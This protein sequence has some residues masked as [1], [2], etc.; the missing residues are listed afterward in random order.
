VVIDKREKDIEP[1]GEGGEVP[2]RLPNAQAMEERVEYGPAD[3]A[4]DEAR[5][6][7]AE[8]DVEE[9]AHGRGHIGGDRK[10]ALDHWRIDAQAPQGDKA[11]KEIRDEGAEVVCRDRFHRGSVKDG[12]SRLTGVPVA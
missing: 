4:H 1:L 8:R 3:G 12:M 6:H 2:A 11:G 5:G 9:T 10:P 7:R